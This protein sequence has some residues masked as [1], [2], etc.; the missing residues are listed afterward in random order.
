MPC[1]NA[2]ICNDSVHAVQD[3]PSEKLKNVANI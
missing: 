2:I 3:T 1:K